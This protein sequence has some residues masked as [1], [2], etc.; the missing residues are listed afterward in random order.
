M[1]FKSIDV[2]NKLT[3]Q[4]VASW[5][6]IIERASLIVDVKFVPNAIGC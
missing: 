4:E 6:Q 5:S 3:R 2:H 1:C